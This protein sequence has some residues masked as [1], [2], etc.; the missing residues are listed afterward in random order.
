MSS[1]LCFDRID[2]V[3]SGFGQLVF[4]LGWNVSKLIRR[5]AE[6]LLPCV[7]CWNTLSRR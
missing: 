7:A 2:E 1:G 4:L 3:G 5:A 6:R